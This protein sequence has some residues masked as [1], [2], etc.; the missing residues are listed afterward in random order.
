MLSK[1][2]QLSVAVIGGK[3]VSNNS[4]F[5]V[6]NFYLTNLFSGYKKELQKLI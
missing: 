1:I 5:C 2:K 6:Q 3:C 4:C